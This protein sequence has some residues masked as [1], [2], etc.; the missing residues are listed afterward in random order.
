MEIRIERK[1]AKQMT[2]FL[3]DFLLLQ[4]TEIKIRSE[5]ILTVVHS[6]HQKYV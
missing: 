1:K 4:L 5:Q 6:A 3:Q 2:R